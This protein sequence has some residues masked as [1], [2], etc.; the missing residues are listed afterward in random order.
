MINSVCGTKNW[1]YIKNS[2]EILGNSQ[3]PDYVILIKSECPWRVK[4]RNPCKNI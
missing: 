4:A 3:F 2:W 1:Q